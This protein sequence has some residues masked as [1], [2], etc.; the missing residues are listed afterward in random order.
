MKILRMEEGRFR[1]YNLIA[2]DKQY[3]VVFCTLVSQC[4]CSHHR[5][6][7]SQWLCQLCKLCSYRQ[8]SS[9]Q[10]LKCSKKEYWNTEYRY[11]DIY[12]KKGCFNFRT[13]QEQGSIRSIPPRCGVGSFF[14]RRWILDWDYGNDHR[15]KKGLWNILW[16]GTGSRA[17][18]LKLFLLKAF[19]AGFELWLVFRSDWF[20]EV[21]IIVFAVIIKGGTGVHWRIVMLKAF[22][23]TFRN[24]KM[25][26]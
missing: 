3:L 26:K 24:S 2:H 22:I 20:E 17:W 7:L 16:F 19:T 23:R 11:I 8:G 6:Q 15:P 9:G 5:A 25:Y 1:V 18:Q 10:K 12:N 21:T 14:E 4:S 13:N